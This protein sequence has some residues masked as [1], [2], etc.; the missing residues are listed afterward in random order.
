MMWA[1]YKSAEIKFTRTEYCTVL[2]IGCIVMYRILT[3]NW[4]ENSDTLLIRL[5]TEIYKYM[6]N[7]VNLQ[8]W[9][10][11]WRMT[12]IGFRKV[13][14]FTVFRCQKDFMDN[15]SKFMQESIFS[16]PTPRYFQ[17]LL[18]INIWATS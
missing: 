4:H 9:P 11:V 18:L 17:D 2:L 5:I 7:S 8:S 12:S 14:C 15:D 13:C 10:K 3:S 16:V 6:F 1:I